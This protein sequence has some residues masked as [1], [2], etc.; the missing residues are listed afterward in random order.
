M[1]ILKNLSVLSV[2]LL[3]SGCFDFDN[4]QVRARPES[5]E[6]TYVEPLKIEQVEGLPKYVVAVEA[7]SNAPIYREITGSTVESSA[8]TQRGASAPNGSGSAVIGGS[9][10]VPHPQNPSGSI[11]GSQNAATS[12]QL[13][14]E[15]ARVT[16]YRQVQKDISVD[17]R[18]IK[19]AAQLTS[20]FSGIENVSV[21]DFFSLTPLSEGRFSAMLRAKEVGPFVV[22]AF[23]TESGTKVET[24]EEK[25]RYFPIV[26]TKKSYQVGMV[27]IDVQ[28]L[29]GRNGVILKSF[30]VQGRFEARDKE[31]DVGV[32]LP[33]YERSASAKSLED[34]ALR[35]AVNEA[36]TRVL[37]ILSENAK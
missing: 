10:P 2:L 21:R 33:L 29:D 27:A 12:Q 24:D 18:A 32:I 23:I 28:V 37:S 3:S 20:A 1:H 7:V 8:A 36:A 15:G 30:P 25:I 26:K 13:A 35:V 4:R 34:Q 22:R 31:L 9:R 14:S 11:P 17:E 5:P 16:E 6:S 19:L